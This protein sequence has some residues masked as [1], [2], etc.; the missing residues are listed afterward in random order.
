[1]VNFR[2]LNNNIVLLLIFILLPI[3]LNVVNLP[4]LVYLRDSIS[5][6]Q[7]SFVDKLNNL[8]ILL[9][10]DVMITMRVAKFYALNGYPGFNMTDLSQPA[11]SYLLP[12]IVSPLFL[13][14]PDSIALSIVVLLGAIA[15]IIASYIVIKKLP[16]LFKLIVL[17]LLFF[18]HSST[19]FL[20]T[21]WEH[22]WQTLFIILFWNELFK[23]YYN[24]DIGIYS[25]VTIGITAALAILFRADSIF[26]IFPGLLFYIL[27]LNSNK[28]SLVKLLPI[29]IFII[30]GIVYTYFQYKWFGTAAPTK[31]RLKAGNLPEATYQIDY[32]IRNILNGSALLPLTLIMIFIVR[33]KKKFNH[34]ETFALIGILL[35]YVYCFIVSDA[36][37]NTRMLIAAYVLSL[38]L[39]SVRVIKEEV[40]EAIKNMKTRLIYILLLT[41]FLTAFST[42]FYKIKSQLFQKP[43]QDNSSSIVSQQLVL[44]KYINT[45]IQPEDG[46]IGLFYLGTVSFVLEKYE[47]A[48]FLGKADE[49]IATSAPKYGPPGHNKWNT[50]L[51]LKK[52]DPIVVPFPDPHSLSLDNK[53]FS[54]WDEYSIELEKRNYIYCKPFKS[55][56]WGIYVA[57]HKIEMFSECALTD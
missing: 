28:R 47:V 4:E 2:F 41:V 55:L 7:L 21:G 44:A 26:I 46:S 11:T 19:S 40:I 34:P 36:F 15:Y 38:Y 52:W 12:I 39:I 6:Q 10:D 49:L 20:F 54:F 25:Y 33:T 53:N 24:K 43:L 18:N 48:D 31:A 8:H 29:F 32:F 1:M 57:P 22:L 5:T 37:D 23:F 42:N 50:S 35:T 56:T 14:F 16:C 30:I 45:K 17:G 51:S 13:I 3:V 27:H 9:H